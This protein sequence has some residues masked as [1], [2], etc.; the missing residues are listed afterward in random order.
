M[1]NFAHVNQM[2]LT[3]KVK[4]PFLTEGY[5]GTEYF[6]DRDH[7]SREMVAALENG[8]NITLYSS[9]RMGKTGL[10]KHVFELFRQQDAGAR[11]YYIDVLHTTTLRGFVMALA[12]AVV[13][14]LDSPLETIMQ[15]AGK[16]FSKLRP[17]ITADAVSGMPSLS[18]DIQHGDEPP[19]LKEICDYL[20]QSGERCYVAIDEFQQIT[21]YPEQ[22]VEALLRSYFQFMPHVTF[23]FSGSRQHL[24]QEMSTHP[25]RPFYQSTQS[26]SL[27]QVDRDCYRDFAQ[28]FFKKSGRVLPDEQFNMVYDQVMGH[29]WYVQYW[30]NKLYDMA[31]GE[32]VTA[33]DVQQALLSILREEDDNF[34][35][36]C[37]LLT[38]A[39][40]RVLRAIAIEGRVRRPLATAFLR[41]HALPATSTV[42]SCIKNLTDKEFLIDDRGEYSVYNRFFMHWLRQQRG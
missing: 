23:I 34:Y 12:D 11:C 15:R 16:F 26:L 32:E 29:T 38:Q 7:E 36:Y 18:F 9:R 22:G 25:A 4:N 41:R 37:R 40:V 33:I 3:M 21:T 14:S 30:L 19:S 6:C 31:Q 35:S 39:E 27:K 8:R 5:A 20:E 24:M 10:I 17:V 28:S 13:G 1:S 2:K 42:R